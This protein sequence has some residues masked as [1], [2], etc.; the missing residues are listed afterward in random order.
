MTSSAELRIDGKLP[1]LHAVPW[2][3][4][5]ADSHDALGHALRRRFNPVSGDRA[6]AER[7]TEPMSAFNNFA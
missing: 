3:E 1:D 6:D 4:L 5:M 7:P 2:L